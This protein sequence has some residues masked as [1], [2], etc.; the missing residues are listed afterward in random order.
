MYPV[1]FLGI[2]AAGGILAATNPAYTSNELTHHFRISETRYV[3]TEPEALQSVL[4]AAEACNIPR[5][6]IL[7]F[8]VLGQSIPVGFSSFQTLLNHG[9]KDWHRFDSFE[10]AK[11]TEACRLFSSGTTGL[12]KATM[13]THRN[14]VAQQEMTRTLAE[15]EY[16]IRRLLVMPMF[17]MAMV[18]MAHVSAL[19]EGI[20]SFVMRSFTLEGFLSN[21][22]RF[23]I[24]DVAMAPPLVVAIIMSPLSKKYSLK[25]LRHVVCGAAPL[26]RASQERFQKLMSESAPFTQVYGMTEATCL[27]TRIPWPEH[28][29]TGS[30]GRLVPNLDVKLLDGEG[31]N[32]EDLSKPG[33]LLIRGPTV[34]PGYIKNTE[35]NARVFDKEG[36]YHTGDIAYCDQ[37]TRLWYLVDRK[38]ELIKV[39]AFQVAPP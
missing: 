26:G 34:I 37:K 15:R 35:E 10:T 24:T 7:I 29:T 18:P 19:K 20:R 9:E 36:F 23:R 33:E 22:E 5:S 14:F 39:K 27:V 16:Q 12:P 1:L 6:N 11:S 28:D 32:I 13:L 3:I 38:K 8:D 21:I 31:R 4:P 2:I 25:C 17:H 30:I